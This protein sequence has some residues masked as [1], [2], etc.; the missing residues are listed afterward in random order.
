MG[1]G[2]VSASRQGTRSTMYAIY[3]SGHST[4]QGSIFVRR[5]IQRSLKLTKTLTVEYLHN[6]VSH[7]SIY[8]N[9]DRVRSMVYHQNMS[10]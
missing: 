5:S 9:A 2:M 7:F 8:S 3:A 4:A 1:Y 10:M 6:C